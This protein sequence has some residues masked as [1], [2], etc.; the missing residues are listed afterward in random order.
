MESHE[1]KC[2]RKE[3][4]RVG[5]RG[6]KRSERVMDERRKWGERARRVRG[7]RGERERARERRYNT[8]GSSTR[9]N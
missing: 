8:V 3:G 5:R 2:E 1:R 6:R 9:Y 4:E 7:E